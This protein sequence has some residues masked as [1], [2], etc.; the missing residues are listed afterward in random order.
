MT[1]PISIRVVTTVNSVAPRRLKASDVIDAISDVKSGVIY[2]T[3]SNVSRPKGPLAKVR[4]DGGA[5]VYFVKP[6]F[7][8]DDYLSRVP[9]ARRPT[10]GL[11]DTLQPTLAPDV[12]GARTVRPMDDPRDDHEEPVKPVDAKTSL[13]RAVLERHPDGLGYDELSRLTNT[14][15]DKIG[16]AVAKLINA[17][18]VKPY[19]FADRGRVFKLV[20]VQASIGPTPKSKPALPVVRHVASPPERVVTLDGEP[21]YPPSE[22]AAP[23]VAGN[24]E[25]PASQGAELASVA[26][27]IETRRIDHMNREEA[28]R[29]MSGTADLTRST[30]PASPGAAPQSECERSGSREPA[31]ADA[32]RGDC[33]QQVRKDRPAGNAA[34]SHCDRIGHPVAERSHSPTVE[35]TE[36]DSILTEN[37]IIAALNLAATV[38]LQVL[39]IDESGPVNR[40]LKN[41][42]KADALL[43]RRL[44]VAAA[45][46][47]V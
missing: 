3:L 12:K 29:S 28:L 2:A 24:T 27:P 1:D 33:A 23:P 19:E 10:G 46:V 47:R 9:G 35:I 25:T 7:D 21:L 39:A 18:D 45:E 31:P 44:G 38:R 11:M 22:P 30:A 43:R 32:V 41:L 40:A 34:T 17:G 26:D 13:L 36:L 14:A 6:G 4:G 15:R 8:L 37:V 42:E 20:G 5:W 16:A